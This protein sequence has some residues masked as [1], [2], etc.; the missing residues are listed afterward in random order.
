MP[1]VPQ[2]RKAPFRL[3]VA[4]RVPFTCL[5][6]LLYPAVWLYTTVALPGGLAEARRLLGMSLEMVAQGELWRLVTALVVPVDALRGAGHMMLIA[7]TVGLREW[8]HGTARA[9]ALYMACD[10]GGKL[11]VAALFLGPTAPWF[12]AVFPGA[13]SDLDVGSSAGA[14]ALLA[15]NLRAFLPRYRRHLF[16]LA[17]VVL[18]AKLVLFPHPVSDLLHVCTF[19]LGWFLGP[20]L[21]APAR[22]G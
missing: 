2:S 17:Q 18:A 14:V 19:S 10:L 7:A 6:M 4:R 21:A 13:V 8:R 11:I 16:A 1:P 22:H 20:R 9:L 15:A 3:A 5:F 12:Q